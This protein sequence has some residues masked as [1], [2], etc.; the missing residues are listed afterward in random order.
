MKNKIICI[1][2]S[3]LISLLS[4][5]ATTSVS[6]ESTDPLLFYKQRLE[7]L[8]E[9]FNTNFSIPNETAT[10]ED[11]S[12]I[13]K[14]YSSMTLEQFDNYVISMVDGTLYTSND[15]SI[16]V[17]NKGNDNIAP[18]SYRQ[19]QRYYYCNGKN[20]NNLYV[21][22]NAA[23]A[24]GYDRYTSFINTGHS[25]DAYPAFKINSSSHN[26]SNGY[27]NVSVTFRVTRYT[28][29]TMSD[30]TLRTVSVTF[31]ANGGNVYGP[32]ISMDL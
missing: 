12:V 8:N 21:V 18:Y 31:T 26:F 3:T 29:A 24:D 1:I 13:I 9:K 32:I 30:A 7:F 6:A 11:Y 16:Q 22:T 14:F 27:R 25:I 17:E 15:E 5:F 19:N 4:I 20:N 10:G 2:T 23:Y 28:S